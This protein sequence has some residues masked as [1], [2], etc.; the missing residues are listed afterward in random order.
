MVDSA[1]A[2]ACGIIAGSAM[3][4]AL[5]AAGVRMLE[6]TLR[7]PPGPGLHGSHRQGGARFM[8]AS[9]FEANPSAH[10]SSELASQL[11]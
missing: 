11:R 9:V 10:H 3:A 7:P 1:S 8:Q 2:V 4:Q 6:I 5:V